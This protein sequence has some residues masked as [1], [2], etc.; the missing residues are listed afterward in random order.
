MAIAKLTK[1]SDSG[2]KETTFPFEYQDKPLIIGRFDPDSGP[3]DVDLNSLPSAEAEYISRH[4]CQIWRDA[5]D[6]WLIKDLGAK[7][8]VFFRAIGQDK[9]ERIKCEQIINDHD[10]IALGN[11]KFEF[12]F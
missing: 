4:H 9:W 8:G 10:Q 2:A 11:V 1:I 3:V 6:N 12:H 7:N 5:L